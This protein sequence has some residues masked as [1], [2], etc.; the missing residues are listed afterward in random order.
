M[1]FMDKYIYI[2]ASQVALVVKN[3]PT[4][5][6]DIRDVG[7]IL[8]WGRVPGGN[9]TPFQHFCLENPMD[10]RTWQAIVHRV[11]SDVTACTHTSHIHISLYVYIKGQCNL[12]FF[13]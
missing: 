5:P 2:W 11:A 8:G 4:N 13:L 10:R 9:G 7:V 12:K 3:L 6:G 1:Y